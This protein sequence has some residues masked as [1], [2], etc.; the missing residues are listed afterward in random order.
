MQFYLDLLAAAPA[1]V[2]YAGCWLESAGAA[3]RH[4]EMDDDP[5]SVQAVPSVAEVT[6]GTE[7]PPTG[8]RFR[9]PG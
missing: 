8:V 1:A 7:F 2:N 6:R 4:D 5:N 9:P 3:E